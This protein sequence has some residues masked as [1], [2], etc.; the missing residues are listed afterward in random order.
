MN[1]HVLLIEAAVPRK[2]VFIHKN[3]KNMLLN[4]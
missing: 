1:I 4:S 2:D 3:H